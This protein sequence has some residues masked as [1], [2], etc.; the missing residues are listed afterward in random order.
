MVGAA[1]AELAGRAGQAGGSR[2]VGDREAEAEAL[3]GAERDAAEVV[4][5]HR[6]DRLARQDARAVPLAAVQH[7]LQERGVVGGR[8]QQAG[9]G[10]ERLARALDV[11]SLAHHVAGVGR[12]LEAAAV[13]DRRIDR[14]QPAQL[15]R[16]QEEVR[17]GHPERVEQPLLQERAEGLAADLLDHRAQDVGVVAVDPPLAGMPVHRQRGEA[18]HRVAHRLVAVGEVPAGDARLRPRVGGRPAVGEQAHAVAD[19]GGV[20][21]QVADG[22]RPARRHDV[23]AAVFVRL[24]DG[25]LGERREVPADRVGDQQLPLLLQQQ[26]PDAGEGLGLRRDAEDAVGRHR[27]LRLDVAVA[28]PLAVG[29]LPAPD[30]DGDRAGEPALVDVAL[31]RQAQAVEA[32]GRHPH[33]FRRDAHQLLGEQR[34]RNEQQ[35]EQDG[36][37]GQA[38]A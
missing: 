26:D 10:R 31:Q 11:V 4:G 20:G 23:V 5:E 29:D 28:D 15:A 12:P 24:G 7:H 27:R 37:R 33:F 8:R 14:R 13:A 19:A 3:A 30:H 21:Q 2:V 25:G 18:G 35:R 38:N 22:D 1:P 36:E 32:L 6:L 9:P 17:V 34:P 16:G